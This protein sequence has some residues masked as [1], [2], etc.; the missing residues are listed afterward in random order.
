MSNQQN[1]IIIERAEE[2][3]RQKMKKNPTIPDE[4]FS[5][6]VNEEISNILDVGDESD[7]WWDIETNGG[8]NV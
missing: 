5:T 7:E 1:D 3:V 2:Y 6:L 4:A 8:E